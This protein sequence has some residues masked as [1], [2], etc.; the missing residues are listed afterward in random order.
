MVN[1]KKIVKKN[2]VATSIETLSL[3]SV[4]N[5]PIMRVF[6]IFFLFGKLFRLV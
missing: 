3:A 6:L 4:E 1:T 5:G 2:D